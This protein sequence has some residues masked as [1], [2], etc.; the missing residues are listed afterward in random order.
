MLPS[1]SPER[2]ARA[3]DSLTP[4]FRFLGQYDKWLA[5]ADEDHCDFALGNPQTMPMKEFVS[6]LQDAATPKSKDWFAYKMSE[7]S[8][9]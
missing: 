9:S 3:H 7:P 5:N 8:S 4:I 1:H 6:T 2:V